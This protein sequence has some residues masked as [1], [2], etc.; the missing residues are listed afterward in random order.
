M[1]GVRTNKRRGK[2][3][4]RDMRLLFQRENIPIAETP[5]SGSGRIKGDLQVWFSGRKFQGECKRRVEFTAYKWFEQDGSDFVIVKADSKP[6]RG[7]KRKPIIMFE[8]G[9]PMW[10]RFIQLMTQSEPELVFE[11]KPVK[12]EGIL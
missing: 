8:I 11:G 12:K 6:G 1:G 5:G 2:D 10:D 4:E 7:L 3:L 9:G